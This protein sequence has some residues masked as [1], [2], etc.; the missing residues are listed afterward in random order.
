MLIFDLE[1]DGFLAKCTKI[2]CLTIYDTETEELTT[3]NDEGGD[4]EPISR[5]VTYL[6]GAEEISGHNIIQFDIPVLHKF[7][8]WFTRTHGIVDTLLLSRLYHPN[9]M[10]LDKKHKWRAMPLQLYGRHSLESYG[11]RLGEYK[12]DFGK[13]CDWECWSQ[14]MQDY[15]E[16]DVIVTNKLWKH[17]QPYL[18]GSR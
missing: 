16:Q 7:Y 3:Y 6:D 13:T 5:G 18:N 17:F 12:G 4:K 8:P 14:D 2:H 9:M 1:T 15:C 10:E 11:Y